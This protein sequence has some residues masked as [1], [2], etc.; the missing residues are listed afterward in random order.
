MDSQADR[1]S[2]QDGKIVNPGSE[3]GPDTSVGDEGDEANEL[4]FNEEQRLIQEQSQQAET[5]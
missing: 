1:N 5:D 2:S 4:R 3:A